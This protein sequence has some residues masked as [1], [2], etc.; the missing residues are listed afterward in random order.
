MRVLQDLCLILAQVLAHGP[1]HVFQTTN[2]SED[3]IRHK[4]DKRYSSYKDVLPDDACA[5]EDASELSMA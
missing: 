4:D 1:M 2:A 5:G 3:T